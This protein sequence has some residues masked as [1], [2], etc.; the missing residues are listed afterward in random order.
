LLSE[1]LKSR[2]IEEAPTN[3][4][5]QEEEKNQVC[6]QKNEVQSKPR[7]VSNKRKRKKKSKSP[8]PA[9]NLAQ[10]KDMKTATF[11]QVIQE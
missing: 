11:G 9:K 2:Q 8:R 4:G 6:S 7:R 1:E 5:I 3:K 10:Y